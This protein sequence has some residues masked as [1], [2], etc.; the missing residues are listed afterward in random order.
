MSSSDSDARAHAA[1]LSIISHD[2][3]APLGVILGAVSELINPQIGPLNDEQRGLLQLVRRSSE[4]LG[5]LASNILFLNRVASA[6]LALA[7]QRV[8]ARTVVRRAI[9]AFERSGELGRIS[10]ATEQ[11]ADSLDVEVDAELA[12][13]AIAN[14]LANAVRFARAQVRVVVEAER[15]GARVLVEDDGPGFVPDSL[16][17]LFDREARHGGTGA[18]GGPAM[19]GLGLVVTKGIV[20]AHG[21]SIRAESLTDPAGR[22]SGARVTMTLPRAP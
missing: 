10:I 19:P 4:K 16:A 7:R 12:T 11:P 18:S 17:I 14:V 13:Q 20:D 2:I 5:R 21:G 22:A 8:D 3:R 9:E 15:D 6:R 1:V